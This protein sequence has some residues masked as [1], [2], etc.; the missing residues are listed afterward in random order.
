MMDLLEHCFAC[1]YPDMPFELANPALE[2]ILNALNH[3]G[4]Y[5]YE[6]RKGTIIKG[7]SL[8]RYLGVFSE[9]NF[10]V[11]ISCLQSSFENIRTLGYNSFHQTSSSTQSSYGMSALV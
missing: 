8:L 5:D 1:L 4:V 10:G 9:P 2:I 6:V 3:F 11:L 7:N